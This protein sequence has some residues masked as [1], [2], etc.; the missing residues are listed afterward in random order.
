MDTRGQKDA[1]HRY[2]DE[3]F[4][5]PN[6]QK[7][8]D[9]MSKVIDSKQQFL[10]KYNA[11]K[12]IKFSDNVSFEE[13][14]YGKTYLDFYKNAINTYRNP[15]NDRINRLAQA[16]NMGYSGYYAKGG[17]LSEKEAIAIEK[18]NSKKI[19]KHQDRVLKNVLNNSKLIEKALIKVFK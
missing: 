1:E 10:D 16:A 7:V 9:Y 14:P 4:N 13:S 6:I 18:E 17:K 12:G 11:D 2:R 15:L 19:E 3:I 5:N 8:D